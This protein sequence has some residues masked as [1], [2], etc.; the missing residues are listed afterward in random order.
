[1]RNHSLSSPRTSSNSTQVSTPF[2]SSGALAGASTQKERGFSPGQRYP[3]ANSSSLL[4]PGFAVSS[5][6]SRTEREAARVLPSP[7]PPAC[8]SGKRQAAPGDLGTHPPLANKPAAQGS[9]D[10]RLKPCSHHQ[11]LLIKAEQWIYKG[12]RSQPVLPCTP[13]YTAKRSSHGYI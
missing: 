12:A 9:G 3:G 1:M 13:I 2:A 11:P 8:G 7:F 5:E 6:S 10:E 4:P